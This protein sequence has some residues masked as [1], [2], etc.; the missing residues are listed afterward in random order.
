MQK[1]RMVALAGS[2]RRGSLNQQL[3]AEVA[4]RTAHAEVQVLNLNHYPLP[5]YD[6][7]LEG[8]RGVPET[9]QELARILATG[10]ALVIAS[11]EYNASMSAVL[12]NVL[13]WV[14]RVGRVFEGKPVMLLSASPGSLGGLQGLGH[15]RA[16]FTALGALVLPGQRAVAKA[17]EA[18]DSEGRL[19]DEQLGSDL[20]R[21]TSELVRVAGRLAPA[22]LC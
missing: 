13:D 14:S 5:L 20:D 11:P 15:L 17:H 10:D 22:A 16:V 8:S 3:V 9:A 21:L 4:R 19:L 18:F 7:D 2:T 1:I 6:G 12:K